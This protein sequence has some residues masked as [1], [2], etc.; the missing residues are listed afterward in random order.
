VLVVVAIAGYLVYRLRPLRDRDRVR[1]RVPIRSCVC[2]GR[3]RPDGTGPLGSYDSDKDHPHIHDKNPN[4]RAG[5]AAA[6]SSA[7]LPLPLPAL[8]FSYL[9]F[10]PPGPISLDHRQRHRAT[11]PSST[12]AGPIPRSRATTPLAQPI[13]DP[14]ELGRSPP[15][16]AATGVRKYTGAQTRHSAHRS[17]VVPLLHEDSRMS[18]AGSASAGCSTSSACSLVPDQSTE[19]A[20]TSV[21]RATRAWRPTWDELFPWSSAATDRL[22]YRAQTPDVESNRAGPSPGDRTGSTSRPGRSATPQS[23]KNHGRSHVPVPRAGGQMDRADTKPPDTGT[24]DFRGSGSLTSPTPSIPLARSGTFG[25]RSTHTR[26]TQPTPAPP[27]SPTSIRTHTENGSQTQQEQE[28]RQQTPAHTTATFTSQGP[29]RASMLTRTMTPTSPP[30]HIRILAARPPRR[31]RLYHPLFRSHHNRVFPTSRSS[32]DFRG[33]PI[34]LTCLTFL[35]Y[36]TCLASLT[37]P[38]RPSQSRHHLST[39]LRHIHPPACTT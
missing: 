7:P 14:Y 21:T 28:R 30:D 5:S 23:D 24:E 1:V 32:R 13:L 3:D 11:S 38:S 25:A 15:R 31:Y 34:P 35:T 8:L 6:S 27:V 10:T 9:D 29:S 18:S 4:A 20:E 17:R 26:S 39:F 16:P 37:R 12:A 36:L 2:L 19:S 33:P 22:L